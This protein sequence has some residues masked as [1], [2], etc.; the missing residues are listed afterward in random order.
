MKNI[1][2]SSQFT[3]E[4]LDKILSSALTL[5]EQFKNG[6]V[7]KLL[8]D[9]VVSCLFFEPST[10]TR[11]SFESAVLHLGG[12][13]ISTENAA[14]SSSAYKGET[15]ED[16]IKVISG[17]CDL[18]V[19]RHPETGSAD[20]AAS[21]SSVPIINA[22]DGPNQHPTQG[23][24]DLYT[25]KKEHKRLD[26]LNVAFI[27][28]LLYGRT[29]HSLLPLLS[30]YENNRFSFVSPRELA[31]PKDYRE[32]LLKN[33]INFT[34]SL[35]LEDAIAQADVIYMMRIQKERFLNMEEYNRIKDSF[36]LTPFHLN[37]IKKDAI[38]MHPLPRVNE[39]HLEVDSDPRAAYF[40]Q[41]KNGL[42]VRMA[43]LLYALGL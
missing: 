22:G 11:L 36:I 43:L 33:K 40:R 39:I 27:G 29:L 24:L 1:L 20:R 21:V 37:N 12:G 10:R 13:I 30:R 25:I 26:N 18:I 8:K 7:D 31:L 15:I 41:A 16:T 17:Y 32:E 23:L 6:K 42:Y 35:P 28:D 2:S 4:D 38:I 14:V 3:K 19:M 5:E 34:E 9:K